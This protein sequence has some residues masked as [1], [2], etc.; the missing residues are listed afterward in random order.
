MQREMNKRPGQIA[1]EVTLIA[2]IDA[3]LSEIEIKYATAHRLADLGRDAAARESVGERARVVVTSLLG[4][5]ENLEHARGGEGR[6]G[7]GQLREENDRRARLLVVAIALA[8]VLAVVI[9]DEHRRSISGPL[10]HPRGTR[11][12]A[13]QRQPRGADDGSV[14]R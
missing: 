2:S 7:V 12:G 5:V 10:T 11:A 13:E 9:V 14:P 8:V 3:K 6:G 1:Q 4:D